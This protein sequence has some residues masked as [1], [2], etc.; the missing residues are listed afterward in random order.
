MIP[1]SY[2]ASHTDQA[3]LGRAPING[4]GGNIPDSS[5]KNRTRS[6]TSISILTRPFDLP[7]EG[8]VGQPS[9]LGTIDGLPEGP[10]GTGVDQ[11]AMERR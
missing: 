8:D 10:S 5:E 3:E 1:A 4:N 11:D 9:T 7:H 2:E 6:P